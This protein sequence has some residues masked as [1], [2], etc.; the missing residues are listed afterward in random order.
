MTEKMNIKIITKDNWEDFV[1][2]LSINPQCSECWCLNHRVAPNEIV[3]G[4]VAKNRME[5]LVCQNR[6]G[7]LLGYLDKKCVAW[8]SVDSL[9]SQ[10]G[11][12][13]I[14]EG[15]EVPENSWTIHCLYI[16][17]KH[18]GQGLSKKLI[19][20]AIEYAKDNNAKKILVFPIP[21]SSKDNDFPEDDEFS[22][23]Y[24]TYKKLGFVEDFRMNDFYQVMSL[25]V[26]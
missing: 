25:K 22:G 3:Y 21:P 2:L 26:S 6:V 19:E 15:N 18:R 1:Q 13:Y 17:P 14:L 9:A 12:D 8:I 7:G 20:A 10:V 5:K 23:R 16:D 4:D 11:H 24:S